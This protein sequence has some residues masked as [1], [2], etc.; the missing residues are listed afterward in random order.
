MR[1]T[2][3]D[4]VKLIKNINIDSNDDEVLQLTDTFREYQKLI[5]KCVESNSENEL[6]EKIY[7]K[8]DKFEVSLKELVDTVKRNKYW[9]DKAKAEKEKEI[10]KKD[11]ISARRI[12]IKCLLF[13]NSDNELLENITI[14]I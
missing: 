11:I 5:I 9:L 6:L 2:L 8:C 4:L 7:A 12:I 3:K 10:I 1:L 13:Q 14:D